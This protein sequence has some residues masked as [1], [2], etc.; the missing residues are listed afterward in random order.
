MNII[1][2]GTDIVNID[3]IKVIYQ[4]YGDAFLDKNFHSLEIKKFSTLP[5]HKK[6]NYLAKRFAAKEA[7]SKAIGTG[8]GDIAFKDIAVLNNDQGAPYILIENGKLK[9]IEEC[10]ILVSLSDDEPFAVAFV[11]ISR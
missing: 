8:I 1:G 5:I 3:R 6:I 7:F 2:I 9:E 4:K 11:I 10:N